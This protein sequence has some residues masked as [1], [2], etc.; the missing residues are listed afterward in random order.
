MKAG[1]WIIH[2]GQFTKLGL[3]RPVGVRMAQE[4]MSF[5]GLAL[6]IWAAVAGESVLMEDELGR[7]VEL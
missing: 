4:G 6:G 2:W 1:C 7:I 5:Q 3:G